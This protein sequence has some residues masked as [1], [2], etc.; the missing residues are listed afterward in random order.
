LVESLYY[1]FNKF[2]LE[3]QVAFIDFFRFAGEN[4][5]YKL[6]D[7]LIQK[8]TN[9]ELVCA[10]LRYYRKYPVEEYKNI[11]LSW[12]NPPKSDD[13]EC[14]SLAASALGKYPGVDTVNALKSQLTLKYWYV[15]RNAAHSISELNVEKDVLIDILDGNDRYAKEQLIYQLNYKK[16]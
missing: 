2:S 3:Y 15:R 11:I 13:W 1:N 8:D 9:K 16:E 14:I 6:K 4:L 5:K 7:I 12:L 10:L